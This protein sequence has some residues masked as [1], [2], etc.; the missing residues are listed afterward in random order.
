MA[1]SNITGQGYSSSVSALPIF[2]QA[3]NF[4]A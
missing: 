3:N 1:F 2:I 4:T